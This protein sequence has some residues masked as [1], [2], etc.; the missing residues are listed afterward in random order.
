MIGNRA[1]FIGDDNFDTGLEYGFL[2]IFF[3]G[4]AGFGV[5]A[6]DVYF[7]IPGESLHHFLNILSERR[8][9]EDIGVA[10]GCRLVSRH[11][12]R[13]VIQDNIGDILIV[14]DGIGDGGHPAVKK[15]G[16]THEDQLFVF[17][18]RVDACAS[19]TAECH[20]G[21]VVH[22]ARKWFV[23]E[24]RVATDVAVKNQIDRGRV[25]LFFHVIGIHKLLGDL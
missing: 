2:Q 17:N 24:H 10:C 16:V 1:L 22:Q 15:S 25:M 19:G 7:G 3:V 11:R 20:G 4:I 13:L 14:F 23:F 21:E 8:I 18:E 12:C 5:G 6:D 9:A